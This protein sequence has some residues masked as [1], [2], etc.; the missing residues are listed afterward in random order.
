MRKS[1]FNVDDNW[2]SRFVMISRGFVEEFCFKMRLNAW[3]LYLALGTFY[4]LSQRRSFPNLEMLE[5]VCPLTRSARSRA[6][7]ELIDLGLVEVWG[8]RLKRKRR[9]FY[10]LVHVD[11]KGH[12]TAER[13]QL[14][15]E[16]IAEL[17]TTGKLPAEYEWAKRAYAKSRRRVF[18][19]R[20][21]LCT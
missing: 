20:V 15:L 10:R 6:L 3:V 4:N 1:S 9:T 18:L 19:H 8:E 12:H 7:R 2:H 13:Q 14:T 21:G 17:D 11:A 16:E 5:A